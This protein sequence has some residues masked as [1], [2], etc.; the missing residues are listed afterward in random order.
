MKSKDVSLLPAEFDTPTQ[1]LTV[2]LKNADK[3]S[4][5]EKQ[6]LSKV[7]VLDKEVVMCYDD[8]TTSASFLLVKTNEESDETS[9]LMKL[10]ILRL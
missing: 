1:T 10:L 9:Q 4:D 3:M 5:V 2:S 8:E 7:L 6:F